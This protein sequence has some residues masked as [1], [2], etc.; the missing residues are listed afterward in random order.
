M[1]TKEIK[2]LSDQE[3]MEKITAEKADLN[4]VTLNH[5]ISPVENPSKIRVSR[6]NIA[7]ML[8]EVNNRKKAAK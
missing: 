8:T 2:G 3:L 6:R 7:R 1:A 5:T 4:K